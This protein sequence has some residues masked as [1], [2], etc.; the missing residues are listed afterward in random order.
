MEKG[1]V[2]L[3]WVLLVLM[4]IAFLDLLYLYTKDYSSYFNNR[5]GIFARATLTPAGGDSLTEKTWLIV[6]NTDGFKV[7]CGLLTPRDKSKRYPAIV[8]MGG[9]ATGKYAVDY[10]LD[11]RN[12]IIIA[13]DYP[14]EPKENYTITEFL[15]DVPE[16]RRALLDMVPSVM[17]LT[18]YLFRRSDVDTA[19][20]VLLGY[21]FGAPFVPCIIANDR[22]AAV[23]VMVYGAG[24]LR[25]LI[26]HNVNR[27]EGK[28]ISEFVGLLGGLL[29][30]P[31]EP[32]RYIEQVSPTPF[33]MINGTD[34]EMIL[35][36]NVEALYA[37][38]KEPKKKIWIESKHVNPRDLELTKK[39]IITL[40]NELAGLGVLDSTAVLP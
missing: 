4:I 38:A 8:L 35:R 12:V 5:R 26:R 28:A 9:K 40:S 13:P 24:E 7:E 18:D 39:I 20:L 31:L 16:M 22:R 36:E 33:I 11:I 14:Y 10:A 3:R 6:E 30:R 34:D 27:Y 2:K 37:K 21:S 1:I 29:L 15:I 23:G 17:L 32:M 25:T 19:K